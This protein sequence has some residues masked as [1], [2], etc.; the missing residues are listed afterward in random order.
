[1]CMSSKAQ[2]GRSKNAEVKKKLCKEMKDSQG[3]T[4]VIALKI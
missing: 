2:E 4:A 1:M 3:K